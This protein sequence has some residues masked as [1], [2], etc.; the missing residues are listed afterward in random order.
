M[1][2]LIAILTLLTF[3]LTVFAQS[4]FGAKINGGL[5]KISNSF[6]HPGYKYTTPFTPSGQVGLF[7]TFHFGDMSILGAE[8]L[9]LQIG[10]KEKLEIDLI[11][12]NGDIAGFSIDETWRHFSYLSLPISYGFKLNKLTINIGFQSSLIFLANSR[13]KVTGKYNGES[14]N[15]DFKSNRLNIAKYDFGPRAGFFFDLTDKLAFEGNYYY[16]LNDVMLSLRSWKWNVHQMTIGI[17]YSILT[18]V[19]NNEYE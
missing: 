12:S 4:E 14:Y 1:K 2:R 6:D 18:T 11:D 9:F 10:G 3:N 17:R 16:G 7:Y 13:I 15:K 5:S 19:L 8:L